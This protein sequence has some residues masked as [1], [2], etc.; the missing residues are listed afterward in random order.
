MSDKRSNDKKYYDRDDDDRD[1]DRDHGNSSSRTIRGTSGADVLNGTS[2]NDAIYAGNGNDR[3]NGGAGNDYIDGG[4]GNDTI[5]GGTGNDRIDGGKGDD[6][7]TGGAGNDVIDGGSGIDVAVFS[8]RFRDYKLTLSRDGGHQGACD[9]DTSAMTVHDLRSGMP[10]GID[11]LKNVEILRFSDG[12]Y[13]DG[14]FYP[15]ATNTPAVIGS[16]TASAVTE[17]VSVT[18]NNLLAVGSISIVDPDAGQA[19]FQTT[20]TS[21]AGNLGSLTLSA[22][23]SY[24]YSVANSAVQHLGAGQTKTESFTITSVDGT[25]KTITFTIAGTND[26]AVIGNPTVNAVTEDAGVNGSGNLTATGSIAIADAD[27]GQSSFQTSVSSAAGNLGSLT[28]SA[29]GS[30]TYSVA[31]GAVQYLGAGQT[32]TESFTI[33][34]VDG[35]A[36]TITFTI[37]G[38]NDAALIGTPTVNAVTE[39]LSV[40]GGGQLTAEGFISIGDA[41]AGQASFQTSVTGADGNLGH[42]VLASDGSY[43]YSVAN[44]AVQF[45]GAGET[46]VDTFAITSFDG[47]TKTISFTINGANDAAEFRNVVA[48]T[49]LEE[50]A[51]N[52]QWG[53]FSAS[54]LT[55]GAWHTDN[56]GNNV[57]IGAG[58]IYGT[59]TSSQVIELEANSGDP[60]NLYTNVVATAGSTYQISFDYSPRAGNESNSSISVFWGGQLVG[61]LS[62]S[63]AVMQHYTLSL[64]APVDGDYRLEFRAGDSNSLGGLLDNISLEQT[65]GAIAAAVTEQT[66]PAGNITTGGTIAFS[67]VD[68]ADS[69]T[70]SAAPVGTTLGTISVIED[71]DTT[72]TGAGGQLSWSYSLDASL[73][74]HLAEGESVVEHFTITLADQNDSTVTKDVAVTIYGTNDAPVAQAIV[75]DAQADG[76]TTLLAAAYTD[77]DSIDTHT[78]SVNTTSTLGLVV[79][80]FDGTFTYDANGKFD[81]LAA[82]ETATDTFTYTVTDNHGGVS[83]ETVTVTVYGRGENHPPLASPIAGTALENGGAST[84]T[85][86]FVDP[87]ANDAHTFTIDVTGTL[88]Q[89]VDNGDGTFTYDAAGQFESLAAGETATDTFSYTVIDSHGEESTA[90]ATVT[91]TGENDAAAIGALTNAEVTEDLAVDGNGNLVATG[92]IAVSDI[93]HDESGFQTTVASNPGNLGTLTIAVDGSYTYTVANAEVQYL[94]ANDSKIETFTISS[95]DGTT[96]EVSFNI[97][98]A[99]DAPEFGGDLAGYVVEAGTDNGGGTPTVAG[100]LTATETDA[101]DLSDAFIAVSTATTSNGGYGKY[102]ISADGS[103]TYTLDNANL[104]V[105]ALNDD[106]APLTDTFT[107][108]ALDGSSTE[109]S[110]DINGANDA[111]VAAPVTLDAILEDAPVTII[112]AAQLI[113]SVSN[114]D[115][116]ALTVTNLSLQNPFQGTLID[117]NNQTWTFIPTLNSSGEVKFNYTVSDA[118]FTSSSVASLDVIAVADAPQLQLPSPTILE[119]PQAFLVAG[120]QQLEQG[121]KVAALSDGTAVIAW[122]VQRAEPESGSEI[123]VRHVT[124]SGTLLGQEVTVTTDP[125]MSSQFPSIAALDDGGFVVTWASLHSDG[126]D[127]PRYDIYGQQFQVSA[128]TPIAV[129][130]GPFQVTDAGSFTNNLSVSVSALP[131]EGFVIAWQG[132]DSANP[133]NIFAKVYSGG[134]AAAV[135]VTQ[136]ADASEFSPAVTTLEDGTFVVVWHATDAALQSVVYGQHYAANG[137]AI[138]NEP[139]QISEAGSN[140]FASVAALMNGGFVVTWQSNDGSTTDIFV[141]QYDVHANP[142]APAFSVNGAVALDNNHQLASVT[143]LD[144]GGYAI[145]WRDETDG[146]VNARTFS[147]A[148]QP[149]SDVFQVH[150][151]DVHELQGDFQPSISAMPNDAFMVTWSHEFNSDNN[152]WART[153]TP[154]ALLKQNENQPLSFEKVA[155]LLDT[156]GSETFGP[157]TLSGIPDGVILMSHGAQ[158]PVVNGVAIVTFEQLGNDLSLPP[159][160]REGLTLHLSAGAQASKFQLTLSASSGEASNSSTATSSL[161][162][163]VTIVPNSAPTIDLDSTQDGSGFSTTFKVNDTGPVAVAGPNLSVVDTDNLKLASAIITLTDAQAGDVLTVGSLPAGIS[164][165]ITGNIVLLS[166]AASVADYNTAIQSVRFDNTNATPD[167]STRHISIVVSDGADFS[168][169]SIASI[170]VLPFVNHAP[171]AIDS[172]IWTNEGTAAAGTLTGFDQDRNSTLTYTVDSGPTFGTLTWNPDGSYVYTPN[173]GYLGNDSFTFYTTDEYGLDSRDLGNGPGTVTIEVAENASNDISSAI[174][175]VSSDPQAP[176]TGTSGGMTVATVLAHP[177]DDVISQQAFVQV[178]AAPEDSSTSGVFAR[179]VAGTGSSAI[180]GTFLLNTGDNVDQGQVCVAAIAPGAIGADGGFVAAWITNDNGVQSLHAG[181]YSVAFDLLDPLAASI[182]PANV[183]FDGVSGTGLSG[184]AI[185]ATGDGSGFALSWLDNGVAYVQQFDTAGIAL[186]SPLAVSDTAAVADHASVVI[187][188]NNNIVVSWA[189]TGPGT[190]GIDVFTRRFVSAPADNSPPYWEDAVR[191]TTA[192]GDQI[193]PSV[194]MLGDD[195]YVVS[196]TDSDGMGGSNGIYVQRFNNDGSP[197]DS[198]VRVDGGLLSDPGHSSVMGLPLGGFVV[199]WQSQQGG[200]AD[201]F[202]NTFFV[203]G[204]NEPAGSTGEFQINLESAGNQVLAQTAPDYFSNSFYAGWSSQ[205]AELSWDVKGALQGANPTSGS[206]KD[207]IG[208]DGNDVMIGTLLHDTLVGGSGDDVIIGN[209]G[210]DVIDGGLG[211]NQLFGGAGQDSFLFNAPGNDVNGWINALKSGQV[212]GTITNFDAAGGDVIDITDLLPS[213]NSSSSILSEFV[214]LEEVGGNTEISVNPDGG[215]AYYSLITLVDQLGLSAQSLYDS[216]ALQLNSH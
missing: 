74:E 197:H 189:A 190:D 84:L 111:P 130:G 42:L 1:D 21:A 54:S 164:A 162:F 128:D 107:V 43:T 127:G 135:S 126:P 145:A 90:T 136:T 73:V 186:T 51:A 193:D 206:P 161:T 183:T 48:S 80:N 170:D 124:A 33:T 166:G 50:V 169:T 34:S 209:G 182:Q 71:S 5:D 22:N 198:A 78:F 171:L 45:L 83:T 203:D 207:L 215:P 17:D 167:L 28:L 18:A 27:Q 188:S 139:F 177:V 60:S 216:G 121:A 138:G 92:S 205:N 39:D 85:A 140:S 148:D 26:A 155:A 213:F 180:G 91:V 122:M 125:G 64:T 87:D 53:N 63:A 160:E 98:G 32:K 119:T 25:A 129:A 109:V 132:G 151:N 137:V 68:L 184:P 61:H 20:I 58:G 67:D 30:Y 201:V 143:G 104:T 108:Y 19:A 56:A 14:R 62:G 123:H 210:G 79:N 94:G 165:S 159:A 59:N 6:I 142:A 24:T 12:E 40:N 81:Y 106:S 117:N 16:P 194:A 156:D 15:N 99:N 65:A 86:S 144:D 212:H 133:N 146:I 69:H 181:L 116:P 157:I 131:N 38:T 154:Y 105:E 2:G 187:D 35:T 152:I 88:G 115:G 150:V 214:R 36:K 10:D 3:I 29:N 118:Q 195:S 196:W 113:S 95:I 44:S 149:T 31:N 8:G 141:R 76:G 75:G 47:T 176:T 37:T 168:N 185:A 9:D 57:E 4:S 134:N 93:D 153:F 77:I 112:T 49:N 204:N 82:G 178:W 100:Q 179:L 208:T 7:I 211:H 114:V 101:T 11:V 46:R 147:S 55:G 52:G 173:A 191:L 120:E 163:G 72:G 41:D 199:S 200:S 202:A 102:T 175:V 103:W 97:H 23:G 110:V 66:E 192:S 158:I 89:V 96:R 172:G 70:V 174:T 13:R